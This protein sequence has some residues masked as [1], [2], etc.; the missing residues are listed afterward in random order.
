MPAVVFASEAPPVTASR[1]VNPSRSERAVACLSSRAA[2]GSFSIGQWRPRTSISQVVSGT[3]AVDAMR[4]TSASAAS[5]SARL[6]ARRSTS[7]RASSA[8][9]LGR[10][11]ERSTPTLQVT[12]GQRPL[13][14]C[15]ATVL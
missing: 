13:S 15:R 1:T 7:S 6:R 9:T 8:T 3:V 10:V 14:S 12:P 4:P 5:R 11:P 2:A